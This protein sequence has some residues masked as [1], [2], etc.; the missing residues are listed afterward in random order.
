MKRKEMVEALA[1]KLYT[2]DL[3]PAIDKWAA[4]D[5]LLFLENSGMKPPRLPEEDCQAIMHV[6][7][8][9]YTF[10]QWEEDA[11]KDEA[12]QK[13]KAWRKLTRRIT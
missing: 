12:V 6:Y 1:T 5:L 3:T 8:G 7:Y 2:E 4:N 13:A 9:N 10:N 11:E